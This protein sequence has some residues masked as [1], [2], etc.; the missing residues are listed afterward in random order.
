M[1]RRKQAGSDASEDPEATASGLAVKRR[2][3]P[4]SAVRR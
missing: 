3:T 4:M 1:G 2:T